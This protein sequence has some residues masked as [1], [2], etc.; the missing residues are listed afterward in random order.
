MSTKSLS[1][2]PANEEHEINGEIT[3]FWDNAALIRNDHKYLP[4]EI[5][6]YSWCSKDYRHKTIYSLMAFE[7]SQSHMVETSSEIAPGVMLTTRRTVSKPVWRLKLL[8]QLSRLPGI[9][10]YVPKDR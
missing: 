1:I 5:E 9:G 6:I 3:L 7:P 4:I 8:R 2:L 10:E